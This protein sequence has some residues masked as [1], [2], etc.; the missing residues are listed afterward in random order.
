LP[1]VVALRRILGGIGVDGAGH[2]GVG[3]DVGDGRRDTGEAL[4]VEVM[5]ARD[6]GGAER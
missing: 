6:I 1:S 2:L 3:D 5:G 4:A